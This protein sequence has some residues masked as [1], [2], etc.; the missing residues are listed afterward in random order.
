MAVLKIFLER[1]FSNDDVEIM[2]NGDKKYQ[3]NN[4]TTNQDLGLAES[5][6]INDIDEY[7][8]ITIFLKSRDISKKIRINTFETTYLSI[9]IINNE[10]KHRISNKPPK[11][12]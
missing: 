12:M 9:S 5:L 6:I 1:G 4:I 3:K 8:N 11:H 2:V 7:N 10:L